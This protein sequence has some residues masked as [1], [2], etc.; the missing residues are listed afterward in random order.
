MRTDKTFSN[1]KPQTESQKLATEKIGAYCNAITHRIQTNQPIS[2]NSR[3]FILHGDSGT[4]KSHLLEAVHNEI[5]KESRTTGIPNPICFVEKRFEVQMSIADMVCFQNKPI[6]IFDDLF[7]NYNCGKLPEFI[8]KD[9]VAFLL[10]AYQKKVLVFCATNHEPVRLFQSLIDYENHNRVESRI[11]EMTRNGQNI[12][13]IEG[14]DARRD[15]A[16]SQSLL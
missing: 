4:G 8:I 11:C 14:P 10:M 1:Y 6:I 16:T 7:Q 3:L 9:F 12:I 15:P 13:H 5:E 2:E